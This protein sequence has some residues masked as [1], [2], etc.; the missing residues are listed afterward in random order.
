MNSDFLQPKN[1][2]TQQDT[3]ADPKLTDAE[4]D[5]ASKD[6]ELLDQVSP[7]VPSPDPELS[8]EDKE[9]ASDKPKV[10]SPATKNPFKKLARW[11]KGLTKKQKVIFVLVIVIILGGL[12]FGLVKALSKKPATVVQKSEE[13]KPEPPKTTEPSK[14]TGVTVPI[15]MNKRPVTGIMIENSPE[16]RPQSGLKDAG[17]VFEA[18]AEGGITRFLSLF[19][20]GQPDYIGPVRS[21]RPYY[22][23]WL[24]AFD[25]PIAHAGGSG[26]GLAKLKADGVRDLDQFAN[27]NAYMR[28]NNRAAPHNLYTTMA[29]LDEL[30]KSK[31]ITSSNFEGFARKPEAASA[32]PTAKSIDFS[33]SSAL[34]SVHYD[35]D[36]ASN[37]YKRSEGGKPHM[38]LKSNSQL[39]PKVVI[40]DVM[41]Y[42]IAPNGVNSTYGTIGSGKAYIFQ[43]GIVTEGIW[44]KSSSKSQIVWKD[45]AGNVIKLNPGQTWIT[46]VNN[47]PSV[48]YK[49]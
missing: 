39:Q 35:Y 3:K 44:S 36:Q 17:V 33:I 34:Y 31:G 24:E 23:D 4:L 49:P 2:N 26:D 21:V 20:E 10:S 19:Q 25:A 8:D 30:N 45:A 16:A 43:D 42:G 22:L 40:A 1:K 9:L 29:K 14:L 7:N 38:D 18:I 46:A 32:T 15:D 47:N 41:T 28:V 13:K 12:S 11:F 48:S 5:A 6:E 27:G 37:S